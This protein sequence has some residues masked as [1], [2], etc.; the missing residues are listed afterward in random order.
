MDKSNKTYDVGYKKPP[1]ATQ[2]RKGQSGN[3][4]GKPKKVVPEFDLG[5]VLQSIDNEEIIIPVDGKRKRMTRA[6]IHLRRLFTQA[7]KGDLTAARLL[8]RMASEYSEPGNSGKY[9]LQCISETQA[10]KRFGRNWQR[11]V[12]EYNVRARGW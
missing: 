5:R 6:E 4:S 1:K 10:A 3:P 8:V 2:Y 11:K 9:G 7:I 12:Q